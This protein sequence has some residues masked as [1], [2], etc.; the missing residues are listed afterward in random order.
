MRHA[1]EFTR[2]LMEESEFG[3]GWMTLG[4]KVIDDWLT[5][6]NGLFIE[7]IGDGKKDGPIVGP[8][9]GLAALDSTRITRKKSPEYP[10]SY[11]DEDGTQYKLHYTRV[12]YASDQPSNI[13]EMRGIGFCS[14]SRCVN[15]AQ[16]L[17]DMAIF[18]EE[19]L[20]SRPMRAILFTPGIPTDV[21]ETTMR[22]S[23][24]MMDNQSLRRYSKIPILGGGN[25]DASV[26]LINLSSL[27]DGFDQ[28]TNTRLAM[29]AMALGFGVPIRWIWPA[30]TSGATKADAMYQHIAGLGG[31]IGRVLNTLTLILGGDPEGKRHTVGKFL[32]S[33]LKLVFDF[34]DDEQDRMHAEIEKMRMDSTAI[35]LETG[36]YTLRVA[37]EKALEAGDLTDAQFAQMELTD[38]RLP[39][40]EDVLS[41]FYAGDTSM[42]EM[43]DLGVEDALDVTNNDP[44][45]MI[46]AIEK[47]QADTRKALQ[48]ASAVSR[49]EAAKQA[50]AALGK[51][52]EAYEKG[53]SAQQQADDTET[54]DQAQGKDQPIEGEG[55]DGKP[56]GD[57]G[58]ESRVRVEEGQDGVGNEEENQE[59][60]EEEKQHHPVWKA[61]VGRLREI[62]GMEGAE[63]GGP[64]SGNYGHSGRPGQRGGSS[65]SNTYASYERI[66]PTSRFVARFTF[67]PRYDIERDWSAWI[68]EEWENKNE[69]IEELL[70]QSG[71][72]NDDLEERWS[73][74]QDESWH[75]WHHR[76]T[77]D[78]DEFLDDIAEEYNIDVRYNKSYGKWQHVH[79]SGLAVWDLGDVNSPEDAVAKAQESGLQWHGFGDQTEGEVRYVGPVP[80][81]DNLHIFEAERT[82]AEPEVYEKSFFT[83]SNVIS[84]A[85]L[86]SSLSAVPKH[87][88]SMHGTPLSLAQ[89]NHLARIAD[90]IETDQEDTGLAWAAARN[91][92]QRMYKQEGARWVRRKDSE[93]ELGE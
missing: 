64:G 27:P 5:T 72:D 9:Q 81:I 84:N 60:S 57:K 36:V 92:F 88:R 22:M 7:V 44:V 45:K 77:D 69:A 91:K 62:A 17:V 59:E 50:L 56:G 31:G 54:E 53:V 67:D 14:A 93:K 82:W 65:P 2:K 85:K 37:R 30:A 16:Q 63:K 8:A 79:H 35:A 48:S 41:L 70:N 13:V 3:Q 83:K 15:I 39:S 74:W 29:F 73:K 46:E 52:R 66:S 43:L 86:W 38:G 55:E 75:S 28:E 33:H 78:Y 12:A 40:G 47:K 42:L 11:M 19:K 80:G 51:L 49:K 76:D 1:D 26:Q 18:N 89:V 24:E 58:P 25:T 34:Q 71:I 32:P 6:D 20:G 23:A 10:I 4:S 90:A 21:V 87:L 61:L 68:G